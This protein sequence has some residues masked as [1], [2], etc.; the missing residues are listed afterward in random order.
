VPV[1]SNWLGDDHP[2]KASKRFEGLD[3]HIQATAQMAADRGWYYRRESYLG[4][5]PDTRRCIC[6]G[7]ILFDALTL[8]STEAAIRHPLSNSAMGIN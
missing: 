3:G 2:S 5:E 8:T 1:G 7:E 6:H 4:L